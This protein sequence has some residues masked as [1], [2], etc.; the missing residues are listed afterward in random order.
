[1]ADA[2]A[3]L[4]AV[5]QVFERLGVKLRKERLGGTG[6]GLCTLRGERVL[7]IDLDA[8]PAT[9]LDRGLAALSTVP[10]LDSM[11]LVPALRERIDHLRRPPGWPR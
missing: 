5:I 11:Y 9:Q 7:F 4:D 3:Q 2:I 10:E 1:M 8:D 6:G